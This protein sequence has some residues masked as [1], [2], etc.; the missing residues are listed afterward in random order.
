MTQ[1]QIFALA[2]IRRHKRQKAHELEWYLRQAMDELCQLELV[3]MTDNGERVYF[4]RC[5]D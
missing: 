3:Q 4:L 1:V 5:K 2:F